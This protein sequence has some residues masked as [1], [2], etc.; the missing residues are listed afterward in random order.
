MANYVAKTLLK[1]HIRHAD[2]HNRVSHTC[3]YSALY[4]SFVFKIEK[5]RK[6]QRMSIIVIVLVNLFK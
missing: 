5:K 2:T 3:M 6:D 1:N 4:C